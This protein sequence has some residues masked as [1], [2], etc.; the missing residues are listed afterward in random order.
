MID[1]GKQNILGIEIDAVDYEAA[2]SRVLE[3]AAN[4]SPLAVSALAVHGV[5][6]GA[7]DRAHRYLLNHL[8]L[9][10]P[11]GQPV[12]WGLN[13]LHRAKL[14][15]RVYGPTLMLKICE[16]AAQ[17]DLPIF[18]FGGTAELLTSLRTNLIARFPNLRIAGVRP[19]LFRRF[20]ADERQ[21]AIDEIRNSGA[22]ITFVGLGCPRQEVWAFEFREAL[23]MPV[24]AVGAAFNFH[25]GQL[26]QAPKILQ[27]HGLEW[28]F[29][30]LREPKRLWKRY[31]LLNPLYVGML[32][33][34]LS[35]LKHFD[36]NDATRPT[37]QLLYG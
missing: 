25:A 11:D 33:L 5:M 4:R 17:K 15:E 20:T 2:V 7:L 16:G 35:G 32:L 18:L 21:A 23:G 19:S 26:A 27:D 9:V 29:R 1:K 28:F 31:M 14:G 30:F 24:I 13:L 10:V 3:A 36:P 12:R 6:T 34:Q 37:D 22:A 8:D